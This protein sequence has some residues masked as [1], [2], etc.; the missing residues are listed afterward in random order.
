MREAKQVREHGGHLGRL[1]HSTT[2][3]RRLVAAMLSD[4]N[5]TT[6]SLGHAARPGCRRYGLAAGTTRRASVT[7]SAFGSESVERTSSGVPRM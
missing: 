2:V 6:S 1:D 5:D 7:V 4:R 3:T